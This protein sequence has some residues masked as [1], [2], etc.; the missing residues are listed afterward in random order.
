[1]LDM[2]RREGPATAGV[3]ER[4]VSSGGASSRDGLRQRLTYIDRTKGLAIL[5]VVIG[6]LIARGTPPGPGIEWFVLVKE[7]IYAFHMPLFMAVSGFVY[8]LRWRPGATMWDDL[9]DARPRVMRLAPAYLSVGLLVFAG[10]LLFQSFTPA[11]DNRVDGAGELLTLL[12]Q[13]TASFCA[14]LWYIYALALLYVAFPLAFR[15]VRGRVPW[16][17]VI[18]MG[19]WWL[20]TS[21]WF[22]WDVLHVLSFFFLI[23]VIAGRHPEAARRWLE[24]LWLPALVPFCLLL[25]AGAHEGSAARWIAAALSIVALPGLMQASEPLRLGLLETMG[26]YTFIIYLTNTIFIGLVKVASYHLGI[27]QASH[28]PLIAVVMVVVAIGGAVLLKRHL[29]PL[30]PALDRMTS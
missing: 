29:L 24:R 30:V 20:P 9:A 1:M 12:S 3:G 17:V 14:F 4:G 8:G 22:A 16:L 11:V 27:W 18:A 26:R 13:P 10:K 21:P 7:A 28:F 5:L 25:P 2:P 23:G 15:A 6:H 19:F